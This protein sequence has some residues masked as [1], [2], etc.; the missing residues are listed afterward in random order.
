MTFRPTRSDWLQAAALALGAFVLYAA[1][2]PR[3]VG[4][5]DDSLFVLSAYFLGIEHPPGDQLQVDPHFAGDTLGQGRHA[6]AAAVAGFGRTFGV[7]RLNDRDRLPGQ[8]FAG[9]CR[10]FVH[11]FFAGLCPANFQRAPAKFHIA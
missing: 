6:K 11:R 8:L 9:G 5:E 2:A 4:L 10:A 7:R 1:T 3:S